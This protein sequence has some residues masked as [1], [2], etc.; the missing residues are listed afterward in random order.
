ME[1]DSLVGSAYTKAITPPKGTHCT[2]KD[3][4]FYKDD[5]NIA[6]KPLRPSALNGFFTYK[7]SSKCINYLL[8]I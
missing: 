2:P 8:P 6:L 5:E 4:L 3:Q 7:L 1:D